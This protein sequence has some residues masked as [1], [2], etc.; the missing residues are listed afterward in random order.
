MTSGPQKKKKSDNHSHIDPM[1]V[2][3]GHMD[4]I[5]DKV[6]ETTTELWKQFKQHYLKMLWNVT[7]D[8]HEFPIQTR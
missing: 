6:H 1:V 3:E 5:R 4:E 8:L 7:K 2:T